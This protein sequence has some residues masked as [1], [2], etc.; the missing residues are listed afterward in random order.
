MGKVLAYVTGSTRFWSTQLRK[1][2]PF[3]A[4]RRAPLSATA[5][6]TGGFQQVLVP[7]GSHE[8][9]GLIALSSRHINYLGSLNYNEFYTNYL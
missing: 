8:N 3:A 1:H 4:S 9:K 6:L 2:L 7:A 5:S